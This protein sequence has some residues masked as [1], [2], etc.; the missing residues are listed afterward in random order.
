MR[1]VHL[2]ALLVI[3]ALLHGCAAGGDVGDDGEVDLARGQELYVQNCAVCHGPAA[4]GTAQGPTFLHEVYV[5]SHHADEAFQ[6]AVAQGVQ[7]HHWDFGP[8]PPIA[9]LSRGDVA[10]ITAYV[11]QLQ[12]EAGII[13]SAD[14]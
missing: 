1:P 7:P 5:P 9:G 13:E 2:S 6:R 3:G 12:V 11:R 10:D 8:M 14:G 4:E